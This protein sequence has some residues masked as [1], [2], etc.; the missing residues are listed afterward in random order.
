ME[1]IWSSSLYLLFKDEPRID[2]TMLIKM[3]ED[4]IHSVSI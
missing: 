3:R 2:I 1:L 4:N